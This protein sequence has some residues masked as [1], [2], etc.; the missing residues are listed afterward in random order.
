MKVNVLT[1]LIF[2]ES[3]VS[4]AK[5]LLFSFTNPFSPISNVI[6]G[7]KAE[8]INVTFNVSFP[9]T[10]PVVYWL[11]SNSFFTS[12]P[13]NSRVSSTY[14]SAGNIEKIFSASLSTASTLLFSRTASPSFTRPPE[15]A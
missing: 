6:A 5:V 8:L 14:P 9:V 1:A 7:V 15:P 4:F 11:K 12:T 10:G 2:T 3:T 13:L